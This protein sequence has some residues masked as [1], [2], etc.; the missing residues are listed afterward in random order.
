[1]GDI[2]IKTRLLENHSINKND[3]YKNH[4]RYLKNSMVAYGLKGLVLRAI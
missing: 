4:L 3:K 1:M 2:H